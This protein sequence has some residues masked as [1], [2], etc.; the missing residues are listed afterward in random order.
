M[1]TLAWRWPAW[2]LRCSRSF[3]ARG[4]GRA[5]PVGTL[6]TRI[7]CSGRALRG[8]GRRADGLVAVGSR[9]AGAFGVHARTRARR[10]DRDP[11][12]RRR[13]QAAADLRWRVGA[14]SFLPTPHPGLPL[15]PPGRF[16][17]ALLCSH[18]RLCH[19]GPIAAARA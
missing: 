15:P 7:A 2:P 13:G 17:Y 14:R 10:W 9:R 12:R 3:S 4:M 18:A 11:G 19:P 6:G 8:W 1:A 16:V 5:H